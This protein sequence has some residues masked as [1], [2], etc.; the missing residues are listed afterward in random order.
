[1]NKETIKEII[2]IVISIILSVIAVKFVIWLL[3]FIIIA[4]LSYIIYINIKKGKKKNT[5]KEKDIKVIH[6]FD[7]EKK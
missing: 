1:M 7:D 4:L 6:D 3:P 5:N 2:Y